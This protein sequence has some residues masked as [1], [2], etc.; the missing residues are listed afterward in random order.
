MLLVIAMDIL[1][2]LVEA[3]ASQGLLAELS[4]QCGGSKTSLYTDDAVIF[5]KP[6]HNDSNIVCLLFQIFGDATRLRTNILKSSVTPIRCSEAEVVA[7]AQ[8]LACPIKEFPIQYPGIPFP[9]WMLRYE[10]YSLC[11][12]SSVAN[13]PTGD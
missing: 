9:N 5:L 4:G 8:H 2:H 6:Q 3:A 12:I 7:I 10:D 11:S 1:H 13:L